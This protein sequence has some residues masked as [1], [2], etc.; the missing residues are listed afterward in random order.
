MSGTSLS[1]VFGWYWGA[2]NGGSFM[3]EGHKAWL[4]VPKSATTTRGFT[5]DGE[6]T[7]I[8]TLESSSEESVYYDLQ[9]RR[10]VNPTVKG[11]YIRNGKK[12]MVK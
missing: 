9:G 10:V 8:T 4:V 12:V 6:T 1:D 5:I 3:T 2:D 11:I 7:G